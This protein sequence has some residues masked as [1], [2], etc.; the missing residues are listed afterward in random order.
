MNGPYMSVQLDVEQLGTKFKHDEVQYVV[1]VPGGDVARLVCTDGKWAWTH[2]FEREMCENN[3]DVK[4][5]CGPKGGQSIHLRIQPSS[6]RMQGPIA[7][8]AS[9]VGIFGGDRTIRRNPALVATETDGITLG[10]AKDYPI[11][12]GVHTYARLPRSSDRKEPKSWQWISACVVPWT[13]MCNHDAC[14]VE[15]FMWSDR[16]FDAEQDEHRERVLISGVRR[17]AQNIGEESKFKELLDSVHKI[18]KEYTMPEFEA[19]TSQSLP[20]ALKRKYVD[21]ND[22]RNST[23]NTPVE[24]LPYHFDEDVMVGDSPLP[25]AFMGASAQA[26]YAYTGSVV[27]ESWLLQKLKQV[28]WLSQY[29]LASSYVSDVTELI[30]NQWTEDNL[31][32]RRLMTD[33]IRIVT[34]HATSSP[35]TEDKRYLKRSSVDSDTYTSALTVP[36]D[37]E[38]GAHSAY[39]IY[40][41]ILF[42]N[43]KDPKLIALQQL[44]AYLGMPVC[45]TGTA[46]NPKHKVNP[47]SGGTHAYGAVIPYRQ[48]IRA[49]FPEAAF[50]KAMEVFRARFKFEAPEDGLN[51]SSIETTLF[52]T[53]AVE[54]PAGAHHED[55]GPAYELV[56]AFA[57]TKMGEPKCAWHNFAYTYFLNENTSVHLLA[58]KAF[59]FA[60]RQLFYTT[61]VDFPFVPLTWNDENATQYSCTFTFAR[62]DNE[63]IGISRPELY[64]KEYFHHWT[65]RVPEPMSEDVFTKDIQLLRCT[66]QPYVPLGRRVWDPQKSVEANEEN[67]AM[68]KDSVTTFTRSLPHV[69]MY[70]YD[71]SIVYPDGKSVTDKLAELVSEL[72]RQTEKR[73]E[74]V[75][76][77][78]DKCVVIVMYWY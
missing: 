69:T 60:H 9:D 63:N 78:Y 72:K 40:M 73:V 64:L 14:F 18:T 49:M 66:R 67:I 6:F 35:Y 5:T 33:V 41:S 47:A 20:D 57:L 74:Y 55:E 76:S 19:M 16:R 26:W 52:S 21:Q 43:W 1:W 44:A 51:S 34:M 30:K 4:S 50:E 11:A 10:T 53:P 8:A 12:F 36:G 62:T 15:T 46:S 23:L 2:P 71:M 59:T 7:Q 27:D 22:V 65:M 61:P 24:G 56:H 75:A 28:S 38:D 25:D 17:M 54:H 39:M 37:C 45:I 77:M 58:F 42:G 13:Y 29:D 48:F 68:A 70:V 3:R 31:V 32:Y